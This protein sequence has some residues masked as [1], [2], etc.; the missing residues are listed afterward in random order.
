MGRWNNSYDDWW[1]C[2]A[3]RN[4]NYK[5]TTGFVYDMNV[6]LLI[7]L[8]IFKILIILLYIFTLCLEDSV[9]K[10]VWNARFC[11]NSCVEIRVECWAPKILRIRISWFKKLVWNKERIV[12]VSAYLSIE[13]FRRGLTICF[14]VF[15]VNGFWD[16]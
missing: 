16:L 11:S 3:I 12:L 15:H 8:V 13:N 14:C 6:V 4:D 9:V 1:L 7:L 2:Y 10:I 5:L